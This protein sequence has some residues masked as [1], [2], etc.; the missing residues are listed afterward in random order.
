VIGYGF[1]QREF[2]GSPSAIGRSLQLDGHAFDIVGVTPPSFFGVEVGRA[3][4]VVVPLCAEPL[5]RGARTALDAPDTWFLSVFGRLKG[6]WSAEKATAQ[7]A[8]ISPPIFANTLPTRYSADDAKSYLNFKLGAFAAGNGVSSLRRNYES[9][10]WLLLATTGVVLFIACANL[11]NLMLA[12]AT[13]R[14]REVAVRLAIG[15]SRGRIV[16]QM[17]AESLLLAGIGAACGAAIAVWLSQFL[18]GF[19][20]TDS[21]RIFVA[22]SARLA[23]LRVC[24]R[25]RPGDLPAVRAPAGDPRDSHAAGRRDESG[26]PRLHRHARAFRPAPGPRD[27]AGGVVAGARG[28]RAVV[29]AQPPQSDDARPGVR[30]GR[31]RHR[32][33]RSAPHRHRLRTAAGGV[34]AGHRAPGRAARRAGRRPRPSSC[35]SAAAG[36]TTTSSSTARSRKSIP[37]STP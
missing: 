26:E 9:P 24:R 33:P 25:A 37:I 6:D 4:D 27:H 21:N 29:R 17:L 16:R 34:R 12:R 22:L 5:S 19:L 36:G 31:R 18:V 20:T 10:L 11:A 23:D 32:Q 13:V 30:A 15:A 2:G 3:F 8:S 14:E 1:W 7:L 28:R 35:R